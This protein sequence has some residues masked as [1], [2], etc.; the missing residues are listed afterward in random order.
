M[1][2]KFRSIISFVLAALLVV[3]IFSSAIAQT[4]EDIQKCKK[5]EKVLSTELN[6][7]DGDIIYQLKYNE[8][9]HQFIFCTIY[10]WKFSQIAKTFY[11]S[12]S[13]YDKMVSMCQS[14]YEML[15]KHTS[16]IST[17]PTIVS[18]ALTSDSEILVCTVDGIDVTDQ[19]E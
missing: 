5:V 9:R 17:T 10:P 13:S 7:S 8:E 16:H 15:V 4:A 14:G 11:S 2:N 6:K 1:K 3:G 12:K 18:A 19:M